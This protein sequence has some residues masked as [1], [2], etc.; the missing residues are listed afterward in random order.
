MTL[1][2]YGRQQNLNGFTG[3]SRWLVHGDIKEKLAKHFKNEDELLYYYYPIYDLIQ[4]IKIDSEWPKKR[5]KLEYFIAHLQNAHACIGAIEATINAW[6]IYKIDKNDFWIF[7]KWEVALKILQFAGLE[8]TY[9]I[10][11]TEDD[12]KLLDIAQWQQ[13]DELYE[14][15][16]DDEQEDSPYPDIISIGY[17]GKPIDKQDVYF[18]IRNYVDTD[19]LDKY[20]YGYTEQEIDYN[21]KKNKAS[22]LQDK[23]LKI[24][25][26][27]TENRRE[28]KQYP[29]VVP[30]I[31][32][33]NNIS[34]QVWNENSI[35]EISREE[36]YNL[37]DMYYGNGASIDIRK[38]LRGGNEYTPSWLSLRFDVFKR[39]NYR[40]QICG[41]TAQ[42]DNVKLE[43][44][45]KLAKSK[46]GTDTLDN[47]W[48]LCFDCNRGKSAK[49]L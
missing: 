25:W 10:G 5:S 43:V 14:L 39:D 6:I 40:C 23:I 21:Q 4:D 44:D 47:L 12:G 49:Q 7:N 22:D 26:P 31:T 46:G 36:A 33:S 38:I 2:A 11:P 24:T 27:I 42:D 48:T 8:T 9:H 15:T 20:L 16:Y 28:K 19:L 34:F 13:I 32:E 45:H 3:F 41:R 1:I 18:E 37:M 17:S 30:R 35:E 29:L